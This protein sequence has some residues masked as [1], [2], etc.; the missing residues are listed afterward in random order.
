[1]HADVWDSG[2][3]IS[4]NVSIRQPGAYYFLCAALAHACIYN[5]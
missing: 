2:S 3:L 1:M 5:W 4:R